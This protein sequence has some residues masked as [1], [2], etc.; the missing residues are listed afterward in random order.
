MQPHAP[1]G[2]EVTGSRCTR[3]PAIMQRL[4]LLLKR[5]HY[6]EFRDELARAELAGD[7]S[8]FYALSSRAALAILEGTE[9]ASDYLDMAEAVASSP[10]ERAVV[11][12]QR[13][14]RDLLRGDALAAAARC[15]ATLDDIGQTEGLWSHLLIALH[16]LG[17]VEAIDATLRSFARLDDECAI[18]LVRLLASEPDLR[19]VHTRPAFRELQERC[20]VG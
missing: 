15:L 20:A 13:A 14:A 8:E 4:D 1:S 12:E 18:R 3:G 17:E 5:R 10:H 2:D 16:R 19:E 11:A 9:L 7:V 6:E